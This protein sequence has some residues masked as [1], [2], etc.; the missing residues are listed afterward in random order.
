MSHSLERLRRLRSEI[1]AQAEDL[2]RGRVKVLRLYN[3]GSSDE[4]C[5]GEH[6]AI[7]HAHLNEIDAILGL[8]EN[9][10]RSNWHFE[11]RASNAISPMADGSSWLPRD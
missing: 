4:D 9:C 11:P 6:L 3:G 1:E 7:W 8:V 2:E 10:L 5:S